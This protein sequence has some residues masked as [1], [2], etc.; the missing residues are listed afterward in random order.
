MKKLL[1]LFTLIFFAFNIQVL[2]QNQMQEKLDRQYFDKVHQQFIYQVSPQAKALDEFHIKQFKDLQVSMENYQLP[3]YSDTSWTY[4]EEKVLGDSA[5]SPN[6]FTYSFSEDIS[7]NAYKSYF[8]AIK[9]VDED[10]YYLSRNQMTSYTDDEID[11]TVTLYYQE[12][13]EDPYTGQKYIYLKDPSE[14]ASRETIWDAFVSSTQTWERQNRRLYYRSEVGYDTL[15]VEYAWDADEEEEFLREER[16]NYS[17]D[18]FTIYETKRWNNYEENGQQAIDYW[19]KQ[20]S[21]LGE[22]GR[23]NY[24]TYKTLNGEGTALQRQDSLGYDY[25]SNGDVKG[26]DYDWVDGAY[27]LKGAYDTFYSEV[28]GSQVADSVINY[29]VVFND[30]TQMYEIDSPLTKSIFEYDE[31]GRQIYVGNYDNPGNDS[32]LRLLNETY[33]TY[34]S[35]GRQIRTVA[36]SLSDGEMKKSYEFEYR[37]TDEWGRISS[38][39]MYYNADGS[40]RNGRRSE[41]AFVDTDGFE[42]YKDFEWDVENEKWVSTR[43]LTRGLY[44]GDSIAQTSDFRNG[45]YSRSINSGLSEKKVAVLNDGPIFLNSPDTTLMF[46]ISAWSIDI[47]RP[48]VEINDLPEGATFDPE[49]RRLNGKLRS[50]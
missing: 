7:E 15:T 36:Y 9:M 45:Y 18:E 17:T 49:T 23:I 31:N 1:I 37:Y 40:I 29:S 8:Q 33:H 44:A 28:A 2:A 30:E 38:I 20:Y 48:N 43:V 5:Y 42:G 46:Y 10:N 25:S 13:Q 24:T 14:G 11:S 35:Q 39:Y 50:R 32:G 3:N 12:G 6:Q 19:T 27:V 47:K 16:R 41:T 22:D 21:S 4:N 26:R 34:D